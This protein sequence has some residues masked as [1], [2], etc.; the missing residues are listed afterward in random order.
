MR[1]LQKIF[2]VCSISLLAVSCS[3]NESAPV[4]TMSKETV[5][6]GEHQSCNYGYV[7]GN[8]SSSAYADRFIN[9]STQ[10][11][12]M[13]TQSRAIAQMFG[14]GEARLRF[15]HDRSNPQSTYNALSYQNG[16]IY[17]GEA[18]YNDALKYG[19]IAPVMILAHEYAHQVQFR[20]SGVP[21]VNENT[22]R[23]VE[24][25]SDGFAGYYLRRGYNASWEDAAP[26]FNFAY[27]IGDYNY[28]NPGHHGTPAQRRSACR[29]GWYLAK[30][31]LSSRDLDRYF[32][33]YYNQ[34]VLPGSLKST[35]NAAKPAFVNSEI[36]AFILS[37]VDELRRINSG[38]ITEKDFEK[39]N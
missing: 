27:G 22:A 4:E 13:Y 25:E 28:N 32:F 2:Y 10:T 20:I 6:H 26:A 33:Y 15:I 16:N 34:Y 37:K 17:F 30:Y 24:L 19:Q 38:E 21:S 31:S 23:A 9:N 3:K 1:T 29:L 14:V 11:N 39:L 7:D 18:I 5:V 35:D 36:D 12:L 8:W